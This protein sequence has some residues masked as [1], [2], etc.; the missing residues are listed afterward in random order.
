MNTHLIPIADFVKNR[1]FDFQRKRVNAVLES[2]V[3]Q[4]ATL[5]DFTHAAENLLGD[6]MREASGVPP[7]AQQEKQREDWERQLP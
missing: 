2:S 3:K 5:F 6:A 4:G 7:L 1:D